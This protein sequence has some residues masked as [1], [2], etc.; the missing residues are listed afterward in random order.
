[1]KRL[2][3]VAFILLLW[4][5]AEAKLRVVTT[6]PD[7]AAIAEAVG[8]DRVAVNAIAILLRNRYERKW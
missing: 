7:L 5:S 8:G 2:M 3:Q 1:M 6:T 4:Q